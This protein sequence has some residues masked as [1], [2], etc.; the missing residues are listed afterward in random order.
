MFDSVSL[1]SVEQSINSV[2]VILVFSCC[3]IFDSINIS[4]SWVIISLKKVILFEKMNIIIVGVFVVNYVINVVSSR[5]I[6]IQL[7][8]CVM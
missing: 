5:L 3:I 4:V 6:V 1:V 2:V 8:I 7:Y